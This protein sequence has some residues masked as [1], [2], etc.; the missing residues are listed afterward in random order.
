MNTG[1]PVA[2]HTLDDQRRLVAALCKPD[3]HPDARAPIQVIE[4]HISF[5]ILD[6][7]LALKLKKPLDLGFVDFSTLERRRFFCE[8]VLRLNRRDAPQL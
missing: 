6:G 3:Q 8:E 4:T 7:H 2:I 1:M 5:V